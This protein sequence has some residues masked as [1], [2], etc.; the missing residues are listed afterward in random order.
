MSEQ[1]LLDLMRESIRVVIFASA[2]PLLVGLV[3]GL[4]ISI[5]QSVT[6][7]QDATLAFVPKIVAIFFSIML[8]GSFMMSTILEFTKSLFS[9]L[10][11]YIR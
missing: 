1:M 7:I 4:G 8:F 2:P 6:S 11:Q 9:N 3:V 10:A 5:F